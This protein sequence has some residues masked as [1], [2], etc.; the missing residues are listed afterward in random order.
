VKTL[1][2]AI[3]PLILIVIF[4]S[5][6]TLVAGPKKYDWTIKA[7]SFNGT[8]NINIIP[9]SQNEDVVNPQLMFKTQ[10]PA[11]AAFSASYK[12]I[13]LSYSQA[14][15]FENEEL[16]NG[17]LETE[18]TTFSAFFD[19]N[20][21]ATEVFL[22]DQTGYILDNPLELFTGWDEQWTKPDYADMRIQTSGFSVFYTSNNSE[23]SIA[24]ITNQVERVTDESGFSWI[25]GVQA[26][27]TIIKN[28]PELN[29]TVNNVGTVSID[30]ISIAS[31]T[32]F[33]GIGF[34]WGIR[35]FYFAPALMLGHPFIKNYSGNTDITSDQLASK[36]F[37]PVGYHSDNF[38]IGMTMLNDGLPLRQNTNEVQINRSHI[39]IFIGWHF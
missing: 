25:G 15:K 31:L 7:A 22:V 12:G 4:F 30:D 23:Y 3:K 35:D 36:V 18:S 27:R 29:V 20:K 9:L 28:I 8:N 5:T 38:F 1:S 32:P 11:A 37:F 6:S 34:H 14:G 21:L 26:K 33:I 13:G 16:L 2:A 24:E 10:V 39:E 19:V 17:N